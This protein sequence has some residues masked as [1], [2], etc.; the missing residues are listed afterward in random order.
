MLKS[1]YC[2]DFNVGQKDQHW[3]LKGIKASRKKE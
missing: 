2:M 3:R 1:Y